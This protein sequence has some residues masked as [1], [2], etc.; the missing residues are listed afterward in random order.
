MKTVIRMKVCACAVLFASLMAASGPAVAIQP[1]VC[2][3]PVGVYASSHSSESDAKAMGKLAWEQKVAS[4]YGANW[5]DFSKAQSIS[6]QCHE[7]SGGW[8]CVTAAK[9]CTPGT[10]PSADGNSTPYTQSPR[11]PPQQRLPAPPLIKKGKKRLRN[12]SKYYPTI[13]NRPSPAMTKFRTIQGMGGMR[14]RLR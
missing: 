10:L 11:D 5:A 6:Y 1:M 4:Q 7:V 8:T 2:K 14:R 3:N 12:T 9:P 13:P